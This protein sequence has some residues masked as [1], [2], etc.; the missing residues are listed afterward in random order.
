MRRNSAS[1]RTAS[2]ALT[3]LAY[4]GRSPSPSLSI[5]TVASEYI[6]SGQQHHCTALI[7]FEANCRSSTKCMLDRSRPTVGNTRSRTDRSP[8]NRIADSR[9]LH[10]RP[11]SRPHPL[12]LASVTSVPRSVKVDLTRGFPCGAL[13]DMSASDRSQ[14]ALARLRR[15]V[16]RG[17]RYESPNTL[18]CSRTC[19]RAATSPR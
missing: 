7:D 11:L 2:T 6:A 10:R 5:T 4:P 16:A 14:R 1:R 15:A 9:P 12:G 8:S 18:R 13:E 3:A 19:R 17:H